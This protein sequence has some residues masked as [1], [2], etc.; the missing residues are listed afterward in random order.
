[1]T[2]YDKATEEIHL[3]LEEQ[4]LGPKHHVKCPDCGATLS[5]RIDEMGRYHATLIKHAS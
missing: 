5:I 2:S 4:R 1:M 3:N